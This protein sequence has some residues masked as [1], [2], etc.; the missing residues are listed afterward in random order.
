VGEFLVLLGAFQTM[1]IYAVLGAVGVILSAVYLLWMYQRVMFGEVTHEA[2]KA[3]QDLAPRELIVLV[4]VVLVIVWIG[5]YPQPFL[6]RMEAS[7]KSVAEQMLAVEKLRAAHM[8]AV[9]TAWGRHTE[10]PLP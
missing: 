1:P 9:D 10:L 8:R 6:K 7:T 2:N 3:L 5:I 4:P